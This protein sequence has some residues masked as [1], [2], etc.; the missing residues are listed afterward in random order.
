MVRNEIESRRRS[1][2][3]IALIRNKI[4][5]G[6][7]PLSAFHDGENLSIQ[8]QPYL[9]QEKVG[10]KTWRLAEKVF[11]STTSP[12]VFVA[13]ADPDSLAAGSAKMPGRFSP[14]LVSYLETHGR[15]V[16]QQSDIGLRALRFSG[17]PAP[18]DD[19]LS[20]LWTRDYSDRLLIGQFAPWRKV[21][22]DQYREMLRGN[23]HFVVF[24]GAEIVGH[25]AFVPFRD[26]ALNR[27]VRA[28]HE[29]VD[30][31]SPKAHR[32]WVHECFFGKIQ[33]RPGLHLAA[34]LANNQQSL[35]HFRAN[36]FT[37]HFLGLARA[38][39]GEGHETA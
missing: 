29:W 5:V 20:A 17:I 32:A 39:N 2:K 26:K 10:A 36:G 21:L 35:R 6:G 8:G 18:Y 13:C 30:S 4:L 27:P 22:D 1:A 23:E 24:R 33:A 3:S 12:R 9:V 11:A 38:K 37:P 15:R 28:V 25:F 16:R 34:I 14:W 31:R 19:Q 7:R